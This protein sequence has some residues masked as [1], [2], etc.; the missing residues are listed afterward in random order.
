VP[1]PVRCCRYQCATARAGASALNASWKVF[2][3]GPSETARCMSQAVFRQPLER[4]QCCF[5]SGR[6]LMWL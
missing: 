3:S 2:E 4:R 6:L 5:G 1:G